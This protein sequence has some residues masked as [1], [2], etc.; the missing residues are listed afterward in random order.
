VMLT[1]KAQLVITSWALYF[2][3]NKMPRLGLRLRIFKS[4]KKN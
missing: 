4:I 1:K 3:F 2:Y